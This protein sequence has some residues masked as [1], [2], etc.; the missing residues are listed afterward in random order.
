MV[1][2]VLSLLSILGC[3]P[4]FDFAEESSDDFE[5]QPQAAVDSDADF[6]AFLEVE[7][8]KSSKPLN[9]EEESNSLTTYDQ[10]ISS[11]IS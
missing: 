4:P 8:V 11:F 3:L 1:C 7:S 2:F 5:E 10:S 9:L 6:K